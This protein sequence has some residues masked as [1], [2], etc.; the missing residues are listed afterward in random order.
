MKAAKSMGVKVSADLN[1]RKK[2]WTPEEA[3]RV[4]S[5]LMEYVDVVVGN[6]EDADKVFGI[7]AGASRCV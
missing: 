7:K 1:Y 2:L 3:N 4:M 5:G 6:E